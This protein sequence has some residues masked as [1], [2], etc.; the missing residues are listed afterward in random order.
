MTKDS[1]SITF[2]SAYK[3][4]SLKQNKISLF[5]L[6]EEMIC[7]LLHTDT[8]SLH[9]Y[10]LSE[11]PSLAIINNSLEFIVKTV[12]EELIVM[13]GNI[14]FFSCKLRKQKRKEIVLIEELF[15]K[16]KVLGKFLWSKTCK[17]E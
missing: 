7:V 5:H 9:E 17:S 1:K 4:Y 15:M 6:N 3:T 14:S 11:F 12:E 10:K 13:L 16:Y 8:R 2:V